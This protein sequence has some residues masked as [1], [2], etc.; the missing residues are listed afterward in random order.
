MLLLP[1]LALPLLTMSLAACG[2]KARVVVQDKMMKHIPAHKLL[3]VATFM[4]GAGDACAC[5]VG[6]VLLPLC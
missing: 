5:I 1:P 3:A 4:A 2:S 6:S